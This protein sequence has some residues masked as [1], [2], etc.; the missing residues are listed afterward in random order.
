MGFSG[1]KS[2]RPNHGSL[3]QL[4]LIPCSSRHK[5][6]TGLR[7]LQGK[8]LRGEGQEDQ[9]SDELLKYSLSD[10]GSQLTEWSKMY[11]GIF[12]WY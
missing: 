9:G 12:G 1:T 11:D 4:V 2:P 6:P 3:G 10:G 5:R 7:R 8:Q